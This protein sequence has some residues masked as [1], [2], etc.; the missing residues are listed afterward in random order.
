VTSHPEWNTANQVI[1]S[2]N[3]AGGALMEVPAAGGEAA[4][5]FKPEARFQ[6][7]YP[8]SI[9]RANAVLFTLGENAPDS[10][11][12]H[13]MKRDTGEH[14][15]VLRSAAA[16]RVLPTGHLLFVRAGALWAVAFDVERL[17][18]V[19]TPI[20][21]VEGVRVEPGGAVQYDVSD[22]GSLVFIPASAANEERSLVFVGPDGRGEPLN[23]PER[24]YTSLQLSPD[25]SSVAVQIGEGDDADVWVGEVGRG[26][27]TRVTR[28]TGFDGAPIWSP[29]GKTVVFAS[30]RADRWTLHRM[31]ADGTGQAAVLATF[32]TVN[33]V[34]PGSWS[35]DGKVVVVE[36]DDDIGVVDTGGQS[37]WKP[38][39]RTPARESQPVVSPDGRWIAYRSSDVERENGVYLQRFPGLGEK[40]PV[41][42]DDAGYMPV[43]SGDGRA[44]FY[45]RRTPTNALMRVSVKAGPD[46]RLD[47]AA[48]EV[49]T[50]FS[51]GY[52]ARP[53]DLSS[54]G[55]RALVISQRDNVGTLAL[56]Q[57]NVVVNWFDELK[58]LVPVK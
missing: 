37:E 39:I 1:F 55:R 11:E 28:E 50:E 14:R 29:D 24:E 40:R 56:R 33:R 18:A 31:A 43:W 46:G 34:V 52:S 53:Y 5:L 38:L 30:S 4:P 45:L 25:R 41:S 42:L 22:E 26:A 27:L 32:D 49:F 12:L 47:I 48:P 20:P 54:D 13:V 9:P 15:T 8:Q 21:V 2:L 10:S 36:V 23:F 3:V 17:E 19:G 35:A 16:G 7:R 58:R 51:F 57:I 44:L 6:A